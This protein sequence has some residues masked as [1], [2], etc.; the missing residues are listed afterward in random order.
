MVPSVPQKQDVCGSLTLQHHMLEPVQRVPR[1]ELLLKD[2]L[3]R[4]PADAPDRRDAESEQAQR[5]RSWAA[6]ETATGT[7]TDW[8]GENSKCPRTFGRR[9]RVLETEEAPAVRSVGETGSWEALSAWASGRASLGAGSLMAPAQ[10][11]AHNTGQGA[12]MG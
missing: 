4:L 11:P 3:K 7:Q 8:E 9:P 6:G 5:P 10:W 2:Y 1:Y 12:P